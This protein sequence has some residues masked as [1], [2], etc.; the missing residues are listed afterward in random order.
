M[1]PLHIFHSS[2]RSSQ[3][4]V[5]IIIITIIII[6][7]KQPNLTHTNIFTKILLLLNVTIAN[8]VFETLDPPHRWPTDMLRFCP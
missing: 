6:R 3:I 8:D 2:V 5:I 7:D 1:W 4:I